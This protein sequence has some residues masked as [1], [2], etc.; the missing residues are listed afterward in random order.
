MFSTTGTV[1]NVYT[2]RKG[3]E[4]YIARC[5]GANLVIE[6]ISGMF[7]VVGY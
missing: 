4:K 3:A 2:S 5:T 6:E 7:Y 1:W